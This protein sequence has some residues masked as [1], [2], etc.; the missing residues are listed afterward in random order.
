M[1][2]KN[3][4]LNIIAKPTHNCNLS[5][6][7]CYVEK[8][9]EKG[10]MGEKLLAQSIE[11][12]SKA[13]Q[14]SHWIWHG[15]EPLTMG[16][17]FYKNVSEVQEFYR[18][19]GKNF[20]NSIQTNGTLIT[21]D[22][23]NFIEQKK[24]FYLST[25][26]DGPQEIHDKI[27][28]YK[29][30]KG[31]FEDV[32]DGLNSTKKRNSSLEAGVICV[33]SSININYPKRL[34]NFFKSEK[35]NVKLNP[36]INS[37]NAK[38]N[39]D[40]LGITPKQYGSFL[41]KFWDIY[42]KDV[43][44][45]GKVI[46]DIDPFME[47]LGNIETNSPL[48]CNYSVSCRESFISLGPQGDIYPCGRFDGVKKFWMGNIK[49]DSLD[50]IMNSKIN[51]ELKKRN[52]KSIKGCKI[53]DFKNICNSG[54]MHN[55]YLSGNVFGKDPYC[56]SYFSLFKKMRNVLNSEKNKVERRLKNEKN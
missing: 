27:R 35:I 11:K 44:R 29:N 49:K 38:E 6:T 17:D 55:A 33:I 52:S 18:K 53:C 4:R 36:L 5:C 19:K 28:I 21:E 37:G 1:S 41:L 7:Y 34:Y 22:L 43:L 9:A 45:E 10:V 2:S 12:I 14:K 23:L 13:Y 20:L 30:G 46:I 51:Q 48:G 39:I 8:D 16:L 54:C 25:S 32:M 47:V 26:L 40:D 50:N 15:G 56:S 31:S 24:D 3:R 42:N